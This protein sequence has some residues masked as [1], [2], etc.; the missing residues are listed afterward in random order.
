MG[1]ESSDP[2][3]YRQ[4]VLK[5]L[6]AGHPG[7]TRMKF[8]ARLHVWW[9]DVDKNIEYHTSA[10]TGCATTARD[11]VRVPLHQWELPLRPWQRVHID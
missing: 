10:C 1:T 6:H 4:A 9:P 11:P 3:K 2:K 5:L 7:T 8:L